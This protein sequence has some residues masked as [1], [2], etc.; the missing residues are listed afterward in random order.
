[1]A[2]LCYNGFIAAM[3]GNGND[4]QS[5]NH[6]EKV[7]FSLRRKLGGY[8][9]QSTLVPIIQAERN[10]VSHF[11]DNIGGA[12][13]KEIAATFN[14][15]PLLNLLSFDCQE[16]KDMVRQITE[17]NHV[18]IKDGHF[19][20]YLTKD[21]ST[22][23]P[24]YYDIH[25]DYM[26]LKDKLVSIYQLLCKYVEMD[27]VISS[28]NDRAKESRYEN[29]NNLT[30]P[31]KF[32]LQAICKRKQGLNLVEKEFIGKGKLFSAT[33][34]E[35]A[36]DY[37]SNIKKL[38]THEFQDVQKTDDLV[39]QAMAD[40][41]QAK[42]QRQAFEDALEKQVQENWTG[43]K[44]KQ[45]TKNAFASKFAK[46]G[47]GLKLAKKIEDQKAIVAEAES[48]VKKSDELRKIVFEKFVNKLGELEDYLNYIANNDI[49]RRIVEIP[50]HFGED[51][52]LEGFKR[53][54]SADKVVLQ[55]ALDLFKQ[56]QK[57]YHSLLTTIQKYI[58][59]FENKTKEKSVKGYEW[60]IE[61]SVRLYKA[62]N[63][64][65]KG[66]RRTLEMNYHYGYTNNAGN[67]FS[68]EFD[69]ILDNWLLECKNVAW[70]ILDGDARAKLQGQF[71]DQKRIAAER[72]Q[73]FCVISKK[74]IEGPMESW[75]KGQKIPYIDP[76][77]LNSKYDSLGA[78]RT[79]DG[80]IPST[81]LYR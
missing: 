60:E 11:N 4:N 77:V 54:K 38:A 18:L 27:D 66:G 45:F 3:N 44:K 7:K 26:S 76:T 69:I 9:P 8:Q 41:G 19:Y 71:C 17:I 29:Y 6:Q 65:A 75:L 68:R 47:E 16:F 30:S 50:L 36:I 10:E 15:S 51:L 56:D 25:F 32:E 70:K 57:L 72:N 80:N 12:K 55:E 43:N 42:Q 21:R 63:N 81:V 73:S 74:I 58:V 46:Q 62:F 28:N 64:I 20:D 61:A 52:I 33:F 53:L 48:S 23:S 14:S 59:R 78:I 40:C 34:K 24:D 13:L 39:N 31:Q 79:R 22:N 49:S 67:Y 2:V 5:T 37:A 1:M 35:L